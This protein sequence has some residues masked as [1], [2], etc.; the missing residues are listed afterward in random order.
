[1]NFLSLENHEH[2]YK[3]FES[4][5]E[6]VNVWLRVPGAFK[7]LLAPR[8]Y[9]AVLLV[10]SSNSHKVAGQTKQWS[11]Q[12][13]LFPV[14]RI[15]E[16]VNMVSAIFSS[17]PPLSVCLFPSYTSL[18]LSQAIQWNWLVADGMWLEVLW[19]QRLSFGHLLGRVNCNSERHSFEFQVCSSWKWGDR[20][21]PTVF[22]VM[23]VHFSLFCH[24]C[25]IVTLPL[26]SFSRKDTKH[27]LSCFS[28]SILITWKLL[29]LRVLL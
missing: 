18:H 10:Q 26:Y 22:W 11:L 3:F 23:L 5:S 25:F 28:P 14:P 16:S 12:A 24:R 1:M 20:S 8:F 6:R 13:P 19:P 27:Q 4:W 2:L 29:L 17:S 7:A 9:E 15:K 21:N